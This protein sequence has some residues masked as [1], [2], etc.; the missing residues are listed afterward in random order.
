M[1]TPFTA[2]A[3]AVAALALLPAAAS[4]QVTLDP[5]PLNP[6]VPHIGPGRPIPTRPK[7]IPTPP[8][9]PP[10]VVSV[11][12]S[13]ISGEA[14]R[15]AG[16]TKIVAPPIADALGPTAYSDNASGT[17]EAIRGCHR[18]KAAEVHIGGGVTSV[19]L[20]CSGS[21]TD[22]YFEGS[23]GNFKPGLDFHNAGNLKGQAQLLKEYATA[24]PRSIKAIAV[25]NGANEFGFAEIAGTC[26][27]HFIETPY[28]WKNLCSDDP[29]L[30]SKFDPPNMT[31]VTSRLARGF[32]NVRKAMTEA[33]YADSEY[34]IVAQTYTSPVP[35]AGLLRYSE[36]GYTRSAIGGC[37]VWNADADWVDTTVV[38]S[39]NRA[40]RDAVAQ[41]GLSNI[42][43]LDARNAFNGRRLCEAGVGMLEEV[44]VS[45][46]QAPG[47]VD[48]TEWVKQINTW[49]RTSPDYQENAHPN[50]WGQMALRNCFRQAYNNGAPRGG[51]CVRGNGLNSRGEP[52]MSLQ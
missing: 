14:G 17:D 20:A 13:A 33:G 47:A 37:P 21:K 10:T 44:G 40:I 43:V 4:A 28:I 25:L 34:Q 49:A 15:W 36:I 16:N 30:T 11:G 3:G 22:T 46:W 52:N 31:V 12:D 23:T 9:G 7:P 41:S 35:P 2:L 51:T 42:V 32:Q 48:R 29:D 50:Y 6:D 8:P 19:N 26:A 18:S 39:F 45:S 5:G 24:N 1:P 27:K 38:D